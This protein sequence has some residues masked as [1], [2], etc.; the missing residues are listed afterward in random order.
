MGLHEDISH[1]HADPLWVPVSD[2]IQDRVQGL[3]VLVEMCHSSM[4]VQII[5]LAAG[6]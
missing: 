4:L 3:Q 2:L 5:K 6:V 1:L